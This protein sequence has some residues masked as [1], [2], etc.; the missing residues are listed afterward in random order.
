MDPMD[1]KRKQ[2]LQDVNTERFLDELAKL[3]NH[4]G[5]YVVPTT[6]GFAACT[7]NLTDANDEVISTNLRYDDS[8]N[9][10]I[11]NEHEIN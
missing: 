8:V 7:I 1:Y 5:I 4:Y 11:T 6:V 2:N 10:Y 9:S 3:S